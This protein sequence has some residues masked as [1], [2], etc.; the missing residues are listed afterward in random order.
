MERI[1]PVRP[2]IHDLF[3]SAVNSFGVEMLEVNITSFENGIFS[4]E[5]ILFDGEKEMTF[6]A[7]TSDAIALALRFRCS[8]FAFPQVIEH[9]GI[10]IDEEIH[11]ETA[12][13]PSLGENTTIGVSDFRHYTNEE[14]ERM[15]DEF[16]EN[17]EY[18]MA[19]AVRDELCR[20]KDRG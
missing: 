12:Q 10:T 9:A 13:S 19:T 16:V 6:T 17:E 7:R 14:L 1:N 20:R 2:L 4:S 3:F 11:D 18:E 8:I 5:V 15:L